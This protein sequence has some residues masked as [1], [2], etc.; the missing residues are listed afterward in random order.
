M[1]TLREC[2]ANPTTAHRVSAEAE[3]ERLSNP[4]EELGQPEDE[5][6][7]TCVWY[8]ALLAEEFGPSAVAQLARGE[9]ATQEEVKYG[10]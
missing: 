7:L 6:E 2:H 9:D 10:E 5:V 1:E 4:G 3:F 8:A